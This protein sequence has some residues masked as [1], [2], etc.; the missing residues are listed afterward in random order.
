MVN[1][2][3]RLWKRWIS[4]LMEL[5]EARRL[6]GR[7][8]R[9]RVGGRR[10]SLTLERLEDRL[11]P[12]IVLPPVAIADAATMNTNSHVTIDVLTNDF[13]P[14]GK[15]DLSSLVITSIPAHG[16]VVVEQAGFGGNEVFSPVV[17][18][19]FGYSLLPS[20]N[21][22]VDQDGTI[23]LR[24]YGAPPPGSPGG[25]GDYPL[26]VRLGESDFSNFD[27]DVFDLRGSFSLP[28]IDG[29]I[30]TY[31]R[32]QIPGTPFVAWL[33]FT[34]SYVAGILNIPL[35]TFRPTRLVYSPDPDFKGTD[36][37][38]YTVQDNGGA[39][40]NEATITVTVLNE[41]PFTNNDSIRT[42]E[43]SPVA[44]GV[45]ANDSD[46]DGTL[47]ESSLMVSSGPAHGTATVQQ[48]AN[49]PI[50]LYVP[51]AGFRGRDVFRYTVQ[52][53]DGATAEAA[54]AVMVLSERPVALDDSATIQA[55]IPV[56]IDVLLNDSVADGLLDPSSLTI[57][58]GPTRGT[59][60][61]EEEFLAADDNG[62]PVG[63]GFA[64]AMSGGF[65]TDADGH[66]KLVVSGAAALN[67]IGAHT[68]SGDY[69][70]FVRLGEVDFEHFDPNVTTVR[71]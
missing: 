56:A 48:S 36:V 29:F 54:V 71:L 62:S 34:P 11:V 32:G 61:I 43:N 66:I 16:T 27:A 7:S 5:P 35:E 45:L 31:F 13:D 1:W 65:A 25:Y 60:S 9:R 2:Q 68:E 28:P 59:V 12:A 23:E 49:G 37:F 53:N 70:L 55:A 30:S 67:T 51:D 58:A 44:I 21:G 4:K 17:L 19:P 8:A 46:Y 50:V 63:N 6:R 20:I 26:F 14:D 42:K 15:L 18:H 64:S 39:V 69:A 3:S 24:T 40:S 22:V 33:D 38:A 47:D 52:D 10:R 41:P 57:T